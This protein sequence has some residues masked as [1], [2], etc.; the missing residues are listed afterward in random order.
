MQTNV[1]AEGNKLVF[2][3][4]TDRFTGGNFVF[5]LLKLLA[6][7]PNQPVIL[8]CSHVETVFPNALV[9]VAGLLDFYRHQG[10]VFQVENLSPFLQKSRFFEPL[11]ASENQR[12]LQQNALNLVWS[13]TTDTETNDLCAEMLRSISQEVVCEEGVITSM[14]WCMNEIMDNVLVHSGIGKGFVMGQV[15][16]KTKHVAFSVYDY[17]QGIFNSLKNSVHAPKDALEAIQLAIQERVTRDKKIGQ[18][19]YVCRIQKRHRVG[20]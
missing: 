1:V 14:A 15:H 10:V 13:Y 4:M 3:N 8:D 9:P 11:V 18:G 5:E 19:Q 2:L 16:K 6:E 12:L 17:G 7:H 20:F